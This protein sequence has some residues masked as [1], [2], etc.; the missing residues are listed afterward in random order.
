MVASFK[1]YELTV[2]AE[3]SI[4]I[5]IHELE[6]GRRGSTQHWIRRDKLTHSLHFSMMHRVDYCLVWEQKGMGSSEAILPYSK[7]VT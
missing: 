7:S 3:I 5:Q 2:A 4:F 1:S 6:N